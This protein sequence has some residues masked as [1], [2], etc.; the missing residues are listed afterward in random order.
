MSVSGKGGSSESRKRGKFL[1]ELDEKK[2][3]HINLA[4]I[5]L[6][7]IFHY[8]FHLSYMPTTISSPSSFPIPPSTS[9][10]SPIYSPSIKKG[11]SLHMGVNKVYHITGG[12]IKLL[13][14][15]Q[16]W[17]RDSYMGNRF[18][19]PAHVPW[20]G[21]DPTFR[22]PTYRPSYPTVIHIEKA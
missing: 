5:S 17:E 18:Q 13:L 22:G 3:K 19:K 8:F 15:H 14:L 1:K 10:L 20:I 11:A 6:S 16:D 4:M 2:R 21:P 9:H 7:I 12:R